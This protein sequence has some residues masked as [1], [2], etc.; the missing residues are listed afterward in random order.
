MLNRLIEFSLRNRLLVVLVAVAIACYA[1][2]ACLNAA[3]WL[4]SDGA[5]AFEDSE[6]AEPSGSSGAG[7]LRE[8]TSAVVSPDDR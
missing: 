8:F 5:P 6:Q 4:L 3:A 2:A 7:S 1:L